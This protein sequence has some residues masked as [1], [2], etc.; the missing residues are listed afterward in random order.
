MNIADILLSVNDLI[1]S[2]ER[3][4]EWSPF[5]YLDSIDFE[6]GDNLIFDFL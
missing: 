6:K 5:S 3:G 1:Y 2:V 4:S